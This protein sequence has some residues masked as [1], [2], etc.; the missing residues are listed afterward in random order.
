VSCYRALAA[1]PRWG[2]TPQSVL[3]WLCFDGD[4][5][6]YDSGSGDTHALDAW[7][8]L[9]LDHVESGT[10]CASL[11]AVSLSRELGQAPEAVQQPLAQALERLVAANLLHQR[12]A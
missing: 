5:V 6:I 12:R 1:E 2:L 11:L 4:W 3:H 7:M 10:D 9:V 8:A